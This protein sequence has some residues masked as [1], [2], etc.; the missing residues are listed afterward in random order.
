V[1]AFGSEEIKKLLAD[2]GG[3]G[4]RHNIQRKGPA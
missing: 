1:V 4:K 2:S 3:G